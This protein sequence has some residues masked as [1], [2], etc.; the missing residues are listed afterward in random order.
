MASKGPS[1]FMPFSRINSKMIL[2][3]IFQDAILNNCKL[4]VQIKRPN[5]KY[6]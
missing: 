1:F 4:K 3:I 5:E 6:F 2:K